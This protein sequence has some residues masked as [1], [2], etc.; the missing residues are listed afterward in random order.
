MDE[1]DASG[2]F[3]A[4]RLKNVRVLNGAENVWNVVLNVFERLAIK[5][6]LM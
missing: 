5:A 3:W 2:H 4:A 6:L 1:R